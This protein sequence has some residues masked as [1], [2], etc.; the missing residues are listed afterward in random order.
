MPP[1]QILTDTFFG[2]NHTDYWYK[3]WLNS[4]KNIDFVENNYK[5]A[6]TELPQE[7]HE[8]LT[9]TKR[10][11]KACEKITEYRNKKYMNIDKNSSKLYINYVLSA[12]WNK[13]EKI[14]KRYFTINSST[15]CSGDYN[16]HLCT[17]RS[18]HMMQKITEKDGNVFGFFGSCH[19]SDFLILLNQLDKYVGDPKKLFTQCFHLLGNPSK[20]SRTIL[21]HESA[22]NFEILKKFA[23]RYK[24]EGYQLQIILENY[25]KK[26]E[27]ETSLCTKNVETLTQ[28]LKNKGYNVISDT[29]FLKELRHPGY[30]KIKSDFPSH[31]LPSL[32]FIVNK[33]SSWFSIK[34]PIYDSVMGTL[35][36]TFLGEFN[37]DIHH[38]LWLHSKENIDFVEKNY[39]Y[40][41][42]NFSQN[43]HTDYEQALEAFNNYHKNKNNHN[44]E[45]TKDSK[46]FIQSLLDDPWNNTNKIENKTTFTING[47]KV[48]AMDI[49]DRLCMPR[50]LHMMHEIA[51]K[52]ENVFGAIDPSHIID[53]L[54]LLLQF[55]GYIYENNLN[56]FF[57][58]CSALSRSIL[59]EISSDKTETILKVNSDQN[60]ITL[61][62]FAERYKRKRYHL[63]IIL[64]NYK[65]KLP[66]K[67]NYKNTAENLVKQLKSKGYNISIKYIPLKELRYATYSKDISK[68]PANFLPALEY[69]VKNHSLL[70]SNLTAFKSNI[71]LRA[72][73]YT[74]YK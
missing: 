20:T 4:Q 2:E 3:V 5:Y 56:N 19:I 55:D 62:K 44:N 40:V 14:D 26:L 33:H 66:K 32:E 37:D 29:I 49:P 13:T 6:V 61:S 34:Q 58:K 15:Y 50:S 67:A 23:K 17:P 18:L 51:G 27:T 46:E 70:N 45:K 60:L 68:F 1:K 53:F 42:K 22:Q 57:V 11:I 43:Q 30:N 8:N 16:D 72:I 73:I 54:V 63:Q 25:K 59:G 28:S 10:Y 21:E 35:T 31:F 64:E 36:D 41:V 9:N 65:E 12:P 39:K 52:N 71:E 38:R 7:E 48:N 47:Q 24:E 74:Y 69:T